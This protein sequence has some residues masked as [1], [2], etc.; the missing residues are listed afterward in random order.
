VSAGDSLC[1]SS[2]RRL[3][4]NVLRYLIA[5]LNRNTLVQSAARSMELLRGR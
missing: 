2:R 4:E 1:G 5:I 3:Y